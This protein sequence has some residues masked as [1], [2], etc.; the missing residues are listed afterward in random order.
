MA[1]E[2][3]ARFQRRGRGCMVLMGSIVGFQGIAGAANYAATKAYVLA[4]GQALQ[5]EMGHQ[6]VDVLTLAPGP[7]NTGF[8]GRAGMDVSDGASAAE[9]VSAALRRLPRGGAMFPG[10]RAKLLGYGT[11]LLPRSLRSRLIGQ[12][13]AKM[14][15]RPTPASVSG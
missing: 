5:R 2:F 14:A 1:H 8:G 7:T 12:A 10:P 9:V 3:G 6:G 4:L 11:Q 15:A 13:M